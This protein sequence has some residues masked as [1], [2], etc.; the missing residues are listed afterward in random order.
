[1]KLPSSKSLSHSPACLFSSSQGSHGFFCTVNLD[2]PVP[3]KS[4]TFPSN[5][6]RAKRA[7]SAMDNDM[8][9]RSPR[10]SKDDGGKDAGANFTICLRYREILFQDFI[11]EDEIVIIE[12]PRTSILEEL[13]DPL[14]RRV[15]GT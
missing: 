8:H 12:E 5:H 9:C 6:L 14:A 1:M 2:Q 7:A 3:K 11:S 10:Q 15:Y 4:D 13:P